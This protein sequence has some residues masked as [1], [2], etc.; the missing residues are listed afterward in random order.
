MGALGAPALE[1]VEFLRRARQS[2]FQ[3]LPVN[4]IDEYGSPYSSS[5]AFAGETLYLDLEDF[6]R[7]GLL[8]RADLDDAWFLTSRADSTG[9]S[10][11]QRD[12]R[13]ERIDYSRARAAR[14]RRCGA[15]DVRRPRDPDRQ[16]RAHDRPD[17]ARAGHAFSD[18]WR[19]VDP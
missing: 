7:E 5:S 2:W 8:D 11:P 19:G 12:A 16:R 15:H 4:P 10:V 6:Y 3:T 14:T 9:S 18:E 13:S 17:E 1:F